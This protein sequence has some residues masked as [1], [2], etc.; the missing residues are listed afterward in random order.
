MI[1]EVET[2]EGSPTSN[3]YSTVEF[4]DDYISL[5]YP[6][7]E[8]WGN[9]TEDQKKMVLV[10][11]T[12]YL[13]SLLVW[14][15]TLRKEEQA[16]SFPRKEFHDSDGRKVKEDVIPSILTE[17]TVEFAVEHLVNGLSR[18]L[19][20]ISREDFAD[21]SD[22][23]ASPKLIKSSN[24]VYEVMLELMHIGYGRNR[25]SLVNIWRA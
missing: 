7:H 24:V 18:E 21:T 8:A 1:F 13:D 16:L 14:T 3:S 23:Y 4:A 12:R 17:I 10:Y 5:F 9:M 11:S 15:S 19:L 20:K 6:E 22:S 25:G 2:G